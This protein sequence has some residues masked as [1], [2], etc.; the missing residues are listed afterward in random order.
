MSTETIENLTVE[1]RRTFPVTRERLFAAWTDPEEIRQWFGPEG[2]RVVNVE[3]D[4]RVGGKYLISAARNSGEICKAVGEFREFTPP[5]RLVYTWSL[6]E[7]PEWDGVDSVITVEFNAQPGGT[8][9]HL[10]HQRLP[11]AESRDGHEQGWTGTLDKLAR[12]LAA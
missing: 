5:S 6:L 10:S 1:L 11:G 8:E 4:R 9:L 7:N 2:V 3:M 12:F